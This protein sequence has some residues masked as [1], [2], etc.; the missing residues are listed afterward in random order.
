MIH[1]P[2]MGPAISPPIPGY[3]RRVVPLGGLTDLEGNPM[4][5]SLWLRPDL[6][7]AYKRRG[8]VEP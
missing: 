3:L 8:V 5:L 6:D 7:R 1:P 2:G 4:L